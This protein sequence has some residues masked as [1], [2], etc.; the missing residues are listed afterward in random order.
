[1]ILVAA[2]QF[3]KRTRELPP[4]CAT[5]EGSEDNGEKEE[6]NPEIGPDEQVLGS[7]GHPDE[8]AKEDD[9]EELPD[10]PIPDEISAPVKLPPI[11][12]I[13]EAEIPEVDG[14]LFSD[15]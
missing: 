9:M 11:P 8:Q 2:L 7:G 14:T 12:D 4:I 15:L 6:T 1:L 10:I 13:A 5:E 3:V